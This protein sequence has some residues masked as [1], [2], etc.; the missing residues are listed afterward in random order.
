M[1]INKEVEKRPTTEELLCDGVVGG[2]VFEIYE[3]QLNS[4]SEKEVC[5]KDEEIKRIKK[6]KEEIIKK[7]DEEKDEEIK[8]IKE[9]KDEEIERIEKEKDEIIKK[10]DEEIKRIKKERDQKGYYFIINSVVFYSLFLFIY[11]LFL[12]FVLIQR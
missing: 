4:V 12:L 7:K 10:K 1:L 3:S 6:E 2:Y 5:L 8:R 9:E 11:S